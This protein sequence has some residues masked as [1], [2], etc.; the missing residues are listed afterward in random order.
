MGKLDAGAT[1]RA[2][3]GRGDSFG[4]ILMS[5]IKKNILANLV[6]KTWSGLVWLVAL[7]IYLKFLGVE[8]YGLVGFY[9][10]LTAVLMIL[11]LGFG[12]TINRELAR[13]S[14]QDGKRGQMRDVLRTL[15]SVY[16][17][18]ALVMGAVLVAL[19]PLIAD[20]WLKPESLTPDAVRDTVVLIVL[21]IAFQ[22]PSALYTGGL[23]GL[24]RQVLLNVVS[25]TVMTLRALG[26]VL[27][28]WLVSP[29][30][31]AFFAWQLLMGIVHTAALSFCLRRNLPQPGH[32]A[33]FDL[34][35][36]KELWRF[37]AG[38]WGIGLFATLLVQM[39][40]ITLSA[41]LPLA[42]FGY[43]SVA[44]LVSSSLY[45][46]I[47]P[48]TWSV[49]PRFAQLGGLRAGGELART[50]HMSSQLAA[51]AILPAAVLV[52]LF[53]SE[54]L[55]LW[56]RDARVAQEGRIVLSLLM[57][58]TALNALVQLPNYLQLASGLVKLGFYTNMS[59]AIITVPCM[60]FFASR[61]GALG[62]AAVWLLLNLAHFVIVV[63]LMHRFLP[64]LETWR[65]YLVDT[66]VPLAVCILILG[67][68]RW[69][70]PEGRTD[71]VKVAYLG[72]ALAASY[73]GA[74]L[75]APDIRKRALAWVN[76]KPPAQN[77]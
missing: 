44:A 15:E 23:S 1:E 46:L 36:L 52:V 6:G 77:T 64:A 56:T 48:I 22:L 31:Q 19:S 40:K 17:A 39:D 5:T 55:W 3:V 71:L 18:V 25:A 74:I 38:A 58:G 60:F 42:A 21:T 69:A 33:R 57:A 66:L 75:S 54:I 73:A 41:V 27:V 63:P 13:L 10:T 70:M 9:L 68:A 14:M 61:Y 50:Y 67:M 43:Y 30:P 28:L 11:D 2:A 51:V 26:A 20:H 37:S 65:W 47:A 16:W 34:Q 76:W 29:T 35:L 53:P 49:F 24:Q 32:R 45:Y 72:V 62:G 7:P 12:P 59:S 8:A 4:A